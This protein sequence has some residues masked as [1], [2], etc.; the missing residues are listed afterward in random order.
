MKCPKCEGR[1]F[2]ELEHGLIMVECDECEGKGEV[3]EWRGLDMANNPLLYGIDS[4][5]PP[6]EVESFELPKE[7]EGTGE[8]AD[9]KSGDNGDRLDTPTTGSGDTSKPT[10][11]KAPKR[12]KKGGKASR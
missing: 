2:T 1:G 11:P 3:E 6:E 7:L 12:K 9:D 10:K 5:I 4:H 8:V